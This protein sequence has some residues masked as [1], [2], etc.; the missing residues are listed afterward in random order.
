ML[1]CPSSTP[2]QKRFYEKLDDF[3]SKV[4]LHKEQG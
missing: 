3:K 4:L 1:P 2:S